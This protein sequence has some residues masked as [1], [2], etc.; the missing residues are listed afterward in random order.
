MVD[1]GVAAL[2]FLMTLESLFHVLSNKRGKLNME[3]IKCSQ[4]S[5]QQPQGGIALTFIC[6]NV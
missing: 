5:C 3:I 1:V 2:L 6:L 4:V